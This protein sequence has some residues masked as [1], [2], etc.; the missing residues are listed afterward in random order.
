MNYPDEFHYETYEICYAI[1]NNVLYGINN[2]IY[3][4][5]KLK[6]RGGIYQNISGFHI[7]ELGEKVF[8]TK[9]EAEDKL[10]EKKK[11]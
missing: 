11:N 9:E 3:F 1:P 6:D 2:D 4:E 8:L 7:S 5:W 10:K